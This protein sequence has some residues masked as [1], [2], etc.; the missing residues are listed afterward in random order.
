MVELSENFIGFDNPRRIYSPDYVTEKTAF[1]DYSELTVAL[2]CVYKYHWVKIDY[3]NIDD[4]IS[5]QPNSTLDE[6]VQ[7]FLKDISNKY[8]SLGVPNETVFANARAILED[9]RR[10]IRT[11]QNEGREPSEFIEESNEFYQLIPCSG[12]GYFSN[13]RKGARPPI[14]SF[15]RCNEKSLL[16]DQ[17]E[18]IIATLPTG[19]SLDNFYNYLNIK[20][21]P[22]NDRRE[23]LS[24]S[25]WKYER[26]IKQLFKIEKNAWNDNFNLNIGNH[27]YL[28]HATHFTHLIGIFK[29]GLLAT[30]PNVVTVNCYQ[31]KGIYFSGGHTGVLK[32]ADNR[33]RKIILVCR[34]AM[35]KIKEL[36]KYENNFDLEYVHP[37]TNENSLM[38]RGVKYRSHFRR[39][40]VLNASTPL[41]EEEIDSDIEYE[42]TDTHDEFLVQNANQIKIEYIVQLY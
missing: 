2:Q 11:A 4:M 33:R 29:D 41:K 37:L 24:L 5:T 7:I 8:L 20:L 6:K 35:G 34:V 3:E 12:N 36:K 26:R 31:G 14:D 16:I 28:F 13:Y 40:E 42:R 19:N 25:N 22:V 15:Q 38:A 10:Q 9:V 30:P 21:Q 18:S 27:Y 17:M 23:F 32:Y 1:D 39:N